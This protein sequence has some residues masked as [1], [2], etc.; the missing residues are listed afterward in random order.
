MAD[1]TAT[2]TPREREVLETMAKWNEDVAAEVEGCGLPE[3][4]AVHAGVAAT[5]RALLAR[6]A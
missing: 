4:A 1:N 6:F 2:L 3:E 5:L